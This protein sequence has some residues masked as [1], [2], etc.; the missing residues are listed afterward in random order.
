VKLYISAG[1][2]SRVVR[3][4]LAEKALDVPMSVLVT[5]IGEARRPDHLARN[6]LGQVPVLETA[7]GAFLSETSAIC[8]YVEELQPEPPLVGRT[9]AERAECR[10]WTRRVDLNVCQ[11]VTHAFRLSPMG[12]RR[13]KQSAPVPEGAES[14]RRLAASHLAWLDEQLRDRP[15]LCGSRFT[16]ADIQLFVFL[17]YAIELGQLLEPQWS[18]LADW[19]ARVGARPS[20]EQ[21]ASIP[22]A[23]GA[24][25]GT[26]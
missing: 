8:E 21:S 1:P 11:L 3:M 6:P 10:M 14:M 15:F 12:F 20:A 19:L 5:A 24:L 16:L 23:A 22:L 25:A 17:E 26:V 18:A 4:F 13:F 9:P 7:D 2:N